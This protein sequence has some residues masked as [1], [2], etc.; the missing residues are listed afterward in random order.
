MH[1]PD[2]AG[3]AFHRSGRLR[4][5]GISA[6]RCRSRSTGRAL[7]CLVRA[8]LSVSRS[9]RRPRASIEY[10]PCWSRSRHDGR[11]RALVHSGQVAST[12]RSIRRSVFQQ[13]QCMRQT[14]D[15]WRRR[16][17]DLSLFGFDVLSLPDS[18]PIRIHGF[19][20]P[21]M[22]LHLLALLA[23]SINVVKPEVVRPFVFVE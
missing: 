10:R 21:R 18:F 20:V 4:S 8:P 19:L 1:S 15:L 22:A 12:C 13:S 6:A 5:A 3:M 11:S 17:R 2:P 7:E 16:A 9:P 14:S 23:F